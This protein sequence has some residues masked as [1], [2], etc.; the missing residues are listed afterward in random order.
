MDKKTAMYIVEEFTNKAIELEKSKFVKL[1]LKDLILRNEG[2]EGLFKFQLLLTQD[3]EGEG[4]VSIKDKKGI[5]KET[6]KVKVEPDVKYINIE[7]FRSAIP[8]IRLFIQHDETISIAN[9]A[10]AYQTL[11]IREYYRKVI[12]DTRKWLTENIVDAGWEIDG[13][14]RSHW[15]ILDTFLYSSILHCDMKKKELWDRWLRNPDS[16]RL[17]F[18]SLHLSTGVI[19]IKVIGLARLNELLL[20]EIKRNKKYSNV[21]FLVE[22]EDFK[23]ESQSIDELKQNACYV[24]YDMNQKIFSHNINERIVINTEKFQ[25][26]WKHV[27]SENNKLVGIY[28][29]IR[30][31]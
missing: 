22:E 23:L 10:R 17:V 29:C 15:K 24:L 28:R 30:L 18:Q 11:T 20:K 8:L 13:E 2:G 31:S 4:T 16:H 19:A 9:L 25:I 27:N 12:V 6:F 7:Y 3:K 5:V 1:I 26:I 14:N 21:L